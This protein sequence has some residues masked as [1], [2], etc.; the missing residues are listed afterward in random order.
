MYKKT[1][2]NSS[3]S[4]KGFTLVELIVVLVVIGILAAIIVPA[5]L[6]YIDRTKAQKDILDARNCM[7]AM[8]VVLSE[9]YAFDTVGERGE[10]GGSGEN[11]K[12]SSVFPGYTGPNDKG[13]VDLSIPKN[14]TDYA[15]RVFK[16]ADDKPYLLIIG[17][18]DRSKYGEPGENLMRAYT[19]YICMYM[20]DKDSKPVFY[21][22]ENWTTEYP[23]KDSEPNDTHKV[24]ANNNML[25]SKN[26]K[27]Q[28][29]MLANGGGHKVTGNDV[30]K[31][32]RNKANEK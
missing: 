15:A 32:L 20:K 28:Y 10:I 21:D 31:F 13:D 14:R 11:Q 2:R 17:T 16:I 18:G 3:S 25:K 4:N 6:G 7:H 8:Q 9:M 24:F 30:W 19:C 27:I 29:Y 22:G 5:L 12:R 1:L 23:G 26:I